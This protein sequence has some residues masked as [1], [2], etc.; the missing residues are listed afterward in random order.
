MTSHIHMIIVSEKEK[1][2]N[3]IRDMK[4]FTTSRLKESIIQ[5]PVESRK[6]WMIRLMTEAGPANK[7]NKNFQLWHPLPL[8]IIPDVTLF[9]N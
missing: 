2:E 5:N 4:K 7:Q 6:E 1:I 9:L 8:T 3:I